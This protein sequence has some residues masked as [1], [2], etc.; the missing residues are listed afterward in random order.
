[1]LTGMPILSLIVCTPLIGILVILFMPKDRGSWMRYGALTAS[2]ITLILSFILFISYQPERGGVREVKDWLELPW[3]K[4]TL[5]LQYH[6]GIDGLSLSLLVLTAL[7]SFV[8]V[9]AS[10]V[11][12][13]K[14]WK[15]FYSLSL[16]LETG[17]LGLLLARDIGLFY[18]FMELTL[19]GL[20]LLIGIWGGERREQS[21]G[22]FFISPW[23]GVG[24]VAECLYYAIGWRL[25]RRAW[26]STR[27]I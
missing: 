23:P 24:I 15:A 18:L 16:W 12:I 13:K 8:A 9:L 21:A 4:S 10:F 7:I 26:V 14:R 27:C 19:V 11:H 1:M 25:N 3:G 2:L 20:F 6:L 5:Q 22:S 17:F